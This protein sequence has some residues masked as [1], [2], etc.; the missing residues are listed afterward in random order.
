VAIEHGKIDGR[1][2]G[3]K[4][5]DGFGAECGEKLIIMKQES[6]KPLA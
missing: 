6:G 4:I 5:H 3:N 1:G 2:Y